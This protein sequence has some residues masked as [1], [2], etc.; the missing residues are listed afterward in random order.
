MKKALTPASTVHSPP[1]RETERSAPGTCG[2][3]GLPLGRSRLQTKANG[4]TF[5]FCCPGCLY[6]FEILFSS[7]G[8]A[9][10]DFRATD[11]YRACVA[12]GLI[13]GAARPEPSAATPIEEIDDQ[14]LEMTLKIEGMWCPA[15]SWLIRE[16]LLRTPGVLEA[17]VFFLSDYARLRYLPH[18]ITPTEI[19]ARIGRFGYRARSAVGETG[20]DHRDSLLRLGIA[21]ILTLNVMMISFALYGGFFE[22]IEAAG[23]GTLSVPLCLLATPVIFY[24]GWPILVRGWQGLRIARPSMDTLIALGSLAAYGYSVWQMVHASL[25][26]YFDTAAMLIT[27]VLVGREVEGRVRRKL[28]LRIS[29]LHELAGSKVRLLADGRENWVEAATV[30]NGDLF[31]VRTGERVAVDGVVVRGNGDVDESVL[32]GESR[33][34]GKAAD[35]DVLAGSLLLDG[36]LHLLATRTGP[37]SSLGQMIT[38]VQKGLAT[39]NPVEQLADRITRWFVPLIL[40]LAAATFLFFLMS[41]ADVGTVLL[42]A[43]TVLVIACPCA[44]GIATPLAKVAVVSAGRGRGIIIRDGASFE[45]AHRLDTVVFDKTGTMSEGSYTLRDIHAPAYTQTEVLRRAAAIEAGADH[46]LARVIR[47]RAKKQNIVPPEAHNLQA[48]SG[49]GVKGSVDGQEVVLGSRRFMA[50]LGHPI[51]ARIDERAA[52]AEGEGLSVIFAAWQGEVQALLAFGDVIRPGGRE[53]VT[54]LAD[55][56]VAIW[57]VSGDSQATTAAVARQ[58]GIAN[59]AGQARPEDKVAL[60]RRLQEEGRLVGMVG[61]GI[62]DAAALA[63]ADVGFATGSSPARLMEEV[64]DVILLGSAPSRLLEVLTLSGRMT[65]AI[66]Q[67]LTLAFL[68]NG[69]GIPLAILGLLNPLLAVCA[70]FASSLTVIGN[71]L[72]VIRLTGQVPLPPAAISLPTN[73]TALTEAGGLG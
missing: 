65:R 40:C 49:L 38:L 32:T 70:M 45:Q 55:R 26:L 11:L 28:N 10:A 52:T 31:A 61:D 29:E 64:A 59:F 34:R 33:P 23:L 3:C 8:G 53:L 46:F 42:R 14:G 47:R 66:R 6:V 63:R 56:G 39:K 68:Y 12:A 44:L 22:D 1:R 19:I 13:P 69:I 20:R 18:R 67:N 4:E 71:T 58:L 41:G 9:V 2:L 50:E 16:I 35:D 54:T 72:R 48:F 5:R 7:S 37:A 30:R 21:A 17:E 73:S 57:L 36:E 60:I 43:L 25:H 15:C 27:L 24:S 51:P 62:N